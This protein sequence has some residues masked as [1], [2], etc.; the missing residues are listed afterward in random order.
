M[1]AKEW[2]DELSKYP[3]NALVGV[4][5]CQQGEDFNNE[6]IPAIEIHDADT[7]DLLGYLW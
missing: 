5:I 2:I 4:E 6:Y 7:Y 3:S 1:T